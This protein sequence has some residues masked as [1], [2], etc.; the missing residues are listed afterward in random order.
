MDGWV[1]TIITAVYF[2]FKDS[3]LSRL[4]KNS[5]T[6]LHPFFSLLMA[7]AGIYVNFQLQDS[8]SYYLRLTVVKGA[9]VLPPFILLF[10]IADFVTSLLL[11]LWARVQAGKNFFSYKYARIILDLI[12]FLL[13]YVVFSTVLFG[14]W[15]KQFEKQANWRFTCLK[16]Q[17]AI[18]FATYYFRNRAYPQKLEEFSSYSVNPIN[19]SPFVYTSGTQLSATVRDEAGNVIMTGTD[20]LGM[21]LYTNDP[22]KF[23][24]Q[25]RSMRDVICPGKVVIPAEFDAIPYRRP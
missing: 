25:R 15:V 20:L 6:K 10:I 23:F 14:I 19:N 11:L 5:V 8:Y 17:V 3:I 4:F 1:W 13:I 18:D 2:S 12:R 9:I 22:Q 16:E 21:E 24:E 7:G